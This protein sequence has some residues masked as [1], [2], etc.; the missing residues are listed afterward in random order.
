MVNANSFTSGISIGTQPPLRRIKLLARIARVTGFDVAWVVDH[1]MGFFPQVL[2]NKEF[3][4]AASP[5]STPHAYF[6]YQALMGH[7]ANQNLHIAVGV[8]EPIRRH[9]VLLAQFAM[10]MS[11]MAKRPPIL[12]IGSGERENV[13]PYGLSFERP[14]ARLEEAL[15][16]IRLCFKSQ[17]PIRFE[18]EFFKLDR[19]IMDLRPKPGNEPQ[20]WIAAHGPRMLR[21]TGEYGD[22][23]YPTL[24]M[25]P[26]EYQKSLREIQAHARRAG[27]DD[28]AIVPGY[29]AF[30]V[31]GKTE[32]HAR[33]LL[34]SPPVR[35]FSLL[36]P[37]YVWKSVGRDHPF[38]EHFRG[39]IDFVPPQYTKRQLDDAMRQVEPELLS[40]IVIWGTPDSVTDK[41]QDYVDAGLRHLVLSPASALAS[42]RD[43]LFSMRASIAIQRRIRKRENSS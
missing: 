32:A 18:G 31:I 42:K 34:D 2:W 26:A 35:L 9:P 16:V 23:W 21:L 28:K 5:G 15:K 4:W 19:A 20:L 40:K 1:F 22:G 12:G 14:V 43:A 24:P 3:T 38:G 29:Q 36:A 13:D 6:D 27:R 8:T 33:Q 39:M 25:S 41:V 17:G 10:T 30:A 37:A 11:H 7:L